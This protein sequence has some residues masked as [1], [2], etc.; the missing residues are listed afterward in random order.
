MPRNTTT[1]SSAEPRSRP[2]GHLATRRESSLTGDTAS[3]GSESGGSESGDMAPP[4]PPLGPPPGWAPPATRRSRLG[5]SRPGHDASGVAFAQQVKG[6]RGSRL[7]RPI[8]LCSS[9]RASLRSLPRTAAHGHAR[10][11][12]LSLA[13]PA[14]DTY[15]VAR[16][17][18]A[19][20]LRVVDEAGGHFVGCR[21]GEVQ[22]AWGRRWTGGTAPWGTGI[23]KV[24]PGA[25][26]TRR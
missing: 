7:P 25:G 9:T 5:A 26:T 22:R 16:S 8:G 13:L 6:P 4:G 12:E 2:A 3:G 23:P 11:P 10:P 15:A 1:P 21:R 18:A 19:R 14:R 17:V 20:G 24:R